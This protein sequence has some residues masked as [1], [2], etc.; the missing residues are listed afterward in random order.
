MKKKNHC[1]IPKLSQRGHLHCYIL[2]S[3]RILQLTLEVSISLALRNS[4]VSKDQSSI[5]MQNHNLNEWDFLGAKVCLFI[6]SVHLLLITPLS[7]R[8][9]Q[10]NWFTSGEIWSDNNNKPFP[11][12]IIFFKFFLGST[13]SFM[14]KRQTRVSLTVN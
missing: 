14:I 11:S 7:K 6:N 5:T 8:S 4:F 1:V 13:V 3:W 9:S 12:L 2:F 10:N